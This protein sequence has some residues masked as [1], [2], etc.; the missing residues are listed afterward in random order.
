MST[1]STAVPETSAAAPSLRHLY[2]VRAAFAVVWAGLLATTGSSLGTLATVLLVVYP[3]VD[4]VAAVVDARTTSDRGAR[5]VA[6]TNAAISVVA[7]VGLGLA[8]TGDVS[9]VLLT[10]GVW[11]VVSGL[12]QLVGALRRRAASGQRFLVVSGGISVLAGVSFAG[13]SADASSVTGLAGYAA[14]GGIFFLVSALRTR[15]AHSV[16]AGG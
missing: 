11:A 13:T 15:R 7:A 1:L 14:L 4:A 5:A 9:D 2:L 3:A 16:G 8:A 10:W 12:A 6:V